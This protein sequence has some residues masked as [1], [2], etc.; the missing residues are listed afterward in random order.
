MAAEVVGLTMCSK[1]GEPGVS[2]SEIRLIK[3]FGIEGDFRQGGERQ[4]SLLSVEVRCWMEAQSEQG[5]CYQR[6]R[7]NVLMKGLRMETLE[8]GSLLSV[9]SAK[10]RI[11]KQRKQCFNEC[12]RF[13]KGISCELSRCAAFAVVEQ[14]GT[15]RI[16]DSISILPVTAT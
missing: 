1:K 5:F 12:A 4:V 8:P 15:I 9:G 2:V 13:S 14:S 11:S 3:G 6:F 10:L 7:E 16:N